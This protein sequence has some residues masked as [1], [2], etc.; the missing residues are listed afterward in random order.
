MVSPREASMMQ[1]RRLFFAAAL[2]LA[3]SAM[4]NAQAPVTVYEGARLITGDGNVI[5]NAAFVVEGTRFIAAGRRADVFVPA[6]ATRV[7]LT[8]KTVIPTMTDLHGHIGF[9]DVAAGTMFEATSTPADLV[10][11]H[12]RRRPPRARPGARRRDPLHP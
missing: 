2:L 10:A 9:Q 4:A 12:P 6:G 3:G 11:H 8:G 1:T 5:E 7:D